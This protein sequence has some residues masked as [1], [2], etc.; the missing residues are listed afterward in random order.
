[1]FIILFAVIKMT[2]GAEYQILGHRVV[3]DGIDQWE[4]LNGEMGQL[5]GATY[6]IYGHHQTSVKRI[7][8]NLPRGKYILRIKIDQL[9]ECTLVVRMSSRKRE[10]E[11]GIKRQG[12]YALSSIQSEGDINVGIDIVSN[13]S[14]S[15]IVISD[16]T[17]I[18]HRYEPE[19]R[20]SI[21]GVTPYSQ[22]NHPFRDIDGSKK[23][24]IKIVS[25]HG[26]NAIRLTYTQGENDRDF[27]KKAKMA[28]SMGLKLILTLTPNCH[29]EKIKEI[30]EATY[31][32]YYQ[33]FVKINAMKIDPKLI[34]LGNEINTKHG[35]LNSRVNWES[36][37][38]FFD[39][40]IISLRSAARGLRAAG[41]NGDI[42][43]HIDRSW[44]GFFTELMRREFDD[45]QVASISCYPKWGDSQTTL[46]EKVKAMNILKAKTDLKFLVIETGAPYMI[47]PNNG[48]TQDFSKEF[49]DEVSPLGQRLHHERLAEL[50]LLEWGER[51]LGMINWG[52]DIT[53]GIHEWEKV[54]WNRAFV[55]RDHH[56]LEGILWFREYA[57]GL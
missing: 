51:G 1:V 22:S 19:S 38:L 12:L 57:K 39:N 20:L 13:E 40:T 25:D 44:P 26:C 29:G 15:R 31:D 17:L 14:H 32:F 52:T 2:Y 10:T 8:Q 9:G 56:A 30:E 5:N 54:T 6:E 35:Y 24:F 7:F 47:K 27:V 36:E 49:M 33:S 3:Q 16:I 50:I 55:D 11:L 53:K 34:V 23:P 37:D 42:S 46:I 48:S 4:V 18:R 43:V 21:V 28:K 45:F 41:Y